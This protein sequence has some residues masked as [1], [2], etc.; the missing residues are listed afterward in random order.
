M[1]RE[2]FHAQLDALAE[3]G[4]AMCTLAGDLLEQATRAVCDADEAAARTVVAETVEMD[5]RRGHA[6]DLVVQL[7]ALQAPVAT[8]LRRVVSAL[9]IVGDA[10]RMGVL[11]IHVAR[12]TLRR[13]PD[14]VV[15]VTIRPV[16]ARMGQI[17]VDLAGR[18]GAALRAAD[19][20]LAE[21]VPSRDPELDRLHL[22][23][24]AAAFDPAWP[25]GVAAAVDVCLLG[26]FYDRFADH[27]AAVA[28]R[29]IYQVTGR[30][31]HA[32]TA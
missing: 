2:A 12:A 7:L 31:G 22:E 9:W 3:H 32:G 26:R 11:A 18:A 17:A 6:E 30:T 19:A 25:Y 21:A 13:Y 5:R 27:A 10:H 8:D 24:L 14:P 29:V 15:P 1:T 20:A 23:L 28:D 16:C 4:A